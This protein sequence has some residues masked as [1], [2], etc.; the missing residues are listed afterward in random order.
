MKEFLKSL[1]VNDIEKK[2]GQFEVYYKLLI[3]W[4]N[5]FN[6]TSITEYDDVIIK[7]FIDS[8]IGEPYLKNNSSVIDIGTGAGFPSIPLKI[9][10][11]D[12]DCVLVDS[13]NKRVGFLQ[14]VIDELGLKKIKA[15]H[16]RAEDLPKSMK[17]DYSVARAVAPLNIL[18]EY[19][20]PFVKQG[21][22][23]IAYKSSDIE[24]E[25]SISKNA[26]K[27]LGGKINKIVDVPLPN[28]DIIR[29]LVIID[30][31]FPTPEKYPRIGNK[32]KLNPL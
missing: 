30:K 28:T 22:Q 4:N 2:L 6:L 9:I 8:C 11:D 25:I 32:P 15:V 1:N 19:C 5:K 13:L 21:G 26:I 18:A 23:F 24:Q 29:K 10:R 27:I 16:S 31:Q 20:L 14:A 17:Y 12:I 3:E 7:H